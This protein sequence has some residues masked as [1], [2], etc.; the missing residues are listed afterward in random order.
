MEQITD[1]LEYLVLGWFS[2]S[3]VLAFF[4]TRGDW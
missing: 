2:V 1:W 3:I 4:L